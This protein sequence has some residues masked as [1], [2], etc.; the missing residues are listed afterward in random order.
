M[1]HIDKGEVE[2]EC[3]SQSIDGAKNPALLMEIDPEHDNPENRSRKSDPRKRRI[4]LG[5]R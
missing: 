1:R 3:K 5:Q 2:K 4:C